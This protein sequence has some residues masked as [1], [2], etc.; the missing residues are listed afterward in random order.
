MCNSLLSVPVALLVLAL[1]AGQTPI[2]A[3]SPPDSVPIANHARVRVQDR[4][5][6]PGW[7]DGQLVRVSL[8]LGGDCVTFAPAARADIGGMTLDGADSLEVWVAGVL[9]TSAAAAVDSTHF[10]GH[11]MKMERARWLLLSAGCRAKR[12]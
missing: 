1:S 8:S 9:P 3:Q 11:W 4:S 10:S 5:L 7:H 12:Q 6:G 2:V